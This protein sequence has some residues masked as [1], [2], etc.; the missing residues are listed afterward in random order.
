V[1]GSTRPVHR[2]TGDLV[3]RLG[4]HEFAIVLPRPG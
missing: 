2:R 1:M 3:A 4:G